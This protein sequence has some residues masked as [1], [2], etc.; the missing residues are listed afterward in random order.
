MAD[1]SQM[2]RISIKFGS[3]LFILQKKKHILWNMYISCV[4]RRVLDYS[5]IN[6]FTLT[7]ALFDM[8]FLAKVRVKVF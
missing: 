6:C 4:F 2:Y 3:L 1:L 7:S 8:I 5:A